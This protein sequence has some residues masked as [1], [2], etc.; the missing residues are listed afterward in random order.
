MENSA[1]PES[2]PPAQSVHRPAS[3]ENAERIIAHCLFTFGVIRRNPESARSNAAQM[4]HEIEKSLYSFGLIT[5]KLWEYLEDAKAEHPHPV[6][7]P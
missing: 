4:I 6:K 3:L 5:P 1:S 2:V 7:V